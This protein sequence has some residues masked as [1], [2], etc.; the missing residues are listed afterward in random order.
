MTR[1]AAI[2][3]P[4]R[5]RRPGAFAR[6]LR[7]TGRWAAILLLALVLGSFASYGLAKFIWLARGMPGDRVAALRGMEVR[8]FQ[9]RSRPSG[10]NDFAQLGVGLPL[11]GERGFL[12]RQRSAGIWEFP[13]DGR[14]SGHLHY[15]S[16]ITAYGIERQSAKGLDL[17]RL[18]PPVAIYQAPGT[19]RVVTSYTVLLDSPDGDFLSIMA[20]CTSLWARAP[21][22]IEWS[23]DDD[24]GRMVFVWRF[25]DRYFLA[26]M[27]FV[28]AGF[29]RTARRRASFRM[30]GSRD[31][32]YASRLATGGLMPTD[33]MADSVRAQ[34]A[35]ANRSMAK[36]VFALREDALHLGDDRFERVFGFGTE[37]LQDLVRRI[38][39][40]EALRL[41]D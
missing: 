37:E 6:W 9:T 27:T 21:A 28:P 13:R 3:P 4:K 35:D 40:A 36:R 16:G 41:G 10:T 32:L 12:A 7:D 14:G 22:A 15:R 25:E 5:R 38:N 23:M 39:R 33:P 17:Y 11:L 34:L 20:I 30:F 18:A 29:G 19:P 24:S 2:A 8:S 26:D 1:A 31:A